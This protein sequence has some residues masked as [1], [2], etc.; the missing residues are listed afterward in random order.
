MGI[1]ERWALWRLCCSTITTTKAMGGGVG[2]EMCNLLAAQ[3]R[4]V[5][6]NK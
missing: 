2:V 4:V 3:L 6:L 1:L 5:Y